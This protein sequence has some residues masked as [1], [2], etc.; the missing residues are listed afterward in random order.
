MKHY[1]NIPHRSSIDRFHV[2]YVRRTG[3][4]MLGYSPE[5][6]VFASV[7]INR[8]AF[9]ILKT[10]AKKYLVR[11]ELQSEAGN[12]MYRPEPKPFICYDYEEC[13]NG[14]TNYYY[15][16]KDRF[17]VEYIGSNIGHML[18]YSPRCGV[19]HSVSISKETFT[20]LKALAK[21]NASLKHWELPSGEKTK[22][23]SCSC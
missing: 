17:Y 7:P 19:Y 5:P 3:Q 15:G 16:S 9:I 20:I 22:T 18:G 4:Y 11:W 23:K 6:D 14:S 12:R 13:R 2:E 1:L 8:E 10:Q 21:Y